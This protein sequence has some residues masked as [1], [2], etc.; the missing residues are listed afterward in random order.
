[1]KTTYDAAKPENLKLNRQT[2]LMIPYSKL[3]QCICALFGPNEKADRALYRAALSKASEM[4]DDINRENQDGADTRNLASL[5]THV[6]FQSAKYGVQRKERGCTEDAFKH[7]FHVMIKLSPEDAVMGILSD[8]EIDLLS[9]WLARDDNG[10]TGMVRIVESTKTLTPAMTSTQADIAGRA[11]QN[12]LEEALAARR[13]QGRQLL[14][15]G[16]EDTEKWQYEDETGQHSLTHTH[17][18]PTNRIALQ[19]NE[20]NGEYYMVVEQRS[21]AHPLNDSKT[22]F[23]QRKAIIEPLQRPSGATQPPNTCSCT[24]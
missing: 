6:V 11:C 4:I 21:S 2:N 20:S 15:R 14:P 7:S 24:R 10:K 12:S 17:P 22:P 5:L 16:A 19:L 8:T 3:G 18:R 23:A 13:S 9:T 1:V